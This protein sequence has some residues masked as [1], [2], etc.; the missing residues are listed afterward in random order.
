[1]GTTDLN[2]PVLGSTRSV[3]AT[4]LDKAWSA[5]GWQLKDFVFAKLR[6]LCHEGHA[7]VSRGNSGSICISDVAAFQ[8]FME[9]HPALVCLLAQSHS[10]STIYYSF[11]EITN[12]L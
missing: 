8:N 10:S 12:E 2:V 7:F 9:R 5:P 11:M 3:K 4:P 6:Q 1:M